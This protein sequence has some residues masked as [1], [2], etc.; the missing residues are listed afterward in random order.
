MPFTWTQ[1]FLWALEDVTA[2]FIAMWDQLDTNKLV[3]EMWGNDADGIAWSDPKT[4]RPPM[5]EEG[6]Y[7]FIDSGRFAQGTDDFRPQ[8]SKFKAAG[9]DIVGGNMLSP[10]S[11]NFWKQ[12][13]QQGLRPMARTTGK[14]PSSRSRLRQ[15]ATSA[16]A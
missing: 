13:C 10:D 16:T 5:L 14:R 8:I 4:G 15:S 12:C 11:V 2:D 1:H 6:G 9:V 3:G 7:K